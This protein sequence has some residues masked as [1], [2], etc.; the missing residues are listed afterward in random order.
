MAFFNNFNKPA[1]TASP[2]SIG[3]GTNFGAAA[4]QQTGGFG[5]TGGGFAGFGATAQPTSTFGGGFGTQTSTATPFGASG[6]FGGATA[7]PASTGFGGFGSAA[8][9]STP[10]GTGGAS[11]SPFGAATTQQ[12]AAPFG[13]GGAATSTF[14]VFGNS[15]FGAGATTQQPTSTF[16]SNNPF[17]GATSATT[18]NFGFGGAPSTPSQ[19]FSLGT[20]PAP[21][22]TTGSMFGGSTMLGAP[23][24]SASTFGGFG[25]AQPFQQQQQQQQQFNI[26]GTTEPIYS[27][28]EDKSANVVLCVIT[29]MDAYKD[30]SI[31]E[32]RL[33]DYKKKEQGGGMQAG[34][35]F[36]AM[37]TQTQMSS[38]FGNSMGTTLGAGTTL[39]SAGTTLGGGTSLGGGSSL[40]GSSLGGGTSLGGFGTNPSSATNPF[41][42]TTSMGTGNT[43]MPFGASSATTG[44]SQPFGASSS[45]FGATTQTS[46]TSPF[47]STPATT[48][49]SLFQG[50][51]ATTQQAPQTPSTNLFGGTFGKP[52]ATAQPTTSLFG[53]TTTQ[54]PAN[55][56]FG[57]GGLTSQPAQNTT[58][59]FG[60][61]TSTNLFGGLQQQQQQQQQQQ[62]A[63]PSLGSTSLFG[64]STA[65]PATNNLFGM[66]QTSNAQSLSAPSSSLFGGLGSTGSGTSFGAPSTNNQQLGSSATPSLSLSSTPSTGFGLGGGGGGLFG[67]MGGSNTLLGANSF[68]T[69]PQQQF[70]TSALGNQPSMIMATS[71]QQQQQQSVQINNSITSQ[72]PYY[73][74]APPQNLQSLLKTIQASPSSSVS[75]VQV[76]P[77]H[78]YT[79]RSSAKLVPRRV[80]GS[81][82]HGVDFEEGIGSQSVNLQNSTSSTATPSLTLDKF[83]T[84]YSKTL[85][86]NTANETEESLKGNGPSSSSLNGSSSSSHS[87]YPNLNLNNE[88]SSSS[89]FSKSTAPHLNINSASPPKGNHFSD[90]SNG[91]G[92][93]SG[94]LNGMNNSSSGQSSYTS[95]ALGT[96][97]SS[98]S[99]GMQ[100]PVLTNKQQINSHAP[101]LTKPTYSC[102][103]PIQELQKLSDKELA[104]V[105]DFII[106]RQ[107]Y[108]SVLFLGDVDVR[109]I[110]IDSIVTIDTREISLYPDDS[111]KP[112]VG[113]GLNR[114]AMVTL[115]QCW[116]LNADGNYRRSDLDLARYEAALKKRAKKDEIQFLEYERQTG[117]WRFKVEHFSKYSAPD[118][119]DDESPAME[120]T[121][122]NQAQ[123]YQQQQQVEV[124]KQKPKFSATVSFDLEDSNEGMSPVR[125]MDDEYEAP[126][127]KII[128]T[129]FIKRTI[130]MRSIDRSNEGLF[131]VD[132]TSGQSNDTFQSLVF[133]NSPLSSPTLHKGLYS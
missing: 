132:T 72:A 58:S 103:P 55:S 34:N 119:L 61:Q 1:A 97:L 16:T 48:G 89:S 45:P 94:S 96:N 67:N 102:R 117:I 111:K 80:I 51:G 84:K 53:A 115:E 12:Q 39:G 28:T 65:Q 79:P 81:S 108:G 24:T 69:Q 4:P 126:Q 110:D 101:K 98:G 86:I 47:G 8:T 36:G 56:L 59:P 75:A 121:P 57:G 7:A 41:G 66:G 18:T 43:G 13:G 52:A 104:S 116:P 122:V 70:N 93:G 125:S 62:S 22:Q 124:A 76:K 23:A 87:L 3:G 15:G 85:S 82:S 20:T 113:Q 5:N 90:M 114:K 77:Y 105:R 68:Q 74:V 112:P 26:T 129:P 118:G 46:T 63:A 127:K 95:P 73:P 17:G 25:G 83:V 106:E 9:S 60:A 11:S 54:Q 109:D 123:Q 71:Q 88:S 32:L 91:S 120:Y 19:T 100:S 133:D 14:N 42:A 35:A 40:F 107:G 128:K 2:F 27:N 10:F 31:E 92:I 38:P 99:V 30:K 21:T 6:G 44:Q 130:P 49:S 37:T 64:S 33:M 50:F 131:T 29:A 78:T